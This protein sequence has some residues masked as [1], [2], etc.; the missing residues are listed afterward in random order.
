MAFNKQNGI[1]LIEI[2]FGIVISSLIILYGISSF[3]NQRQNEA[4]EQTV[5]EMKHLLQLAVMYHAQEDVWPSAIAVVKGQ[6]ILTEE[7][8][9]SPWPGDGMDPN[10]NVQ[11]TLCPHRAVYHVA[12]F[13]NQS[14][15]QTAKYFGISLHLSD[16]RLVNRIAALLPAAILTDPYTLTA[17]VSALV[18]PKQD[19]GWIMSGGIVDDG[20]VIDMPK[21][22]D[23]YEGHFIESPQNFT[24]DSRDYLW[25]EKIFNRGKYYVNFQ[26]S[27]EGKPG[28]N[29]PEGQPYIIARHHKYEN[30]KTFMSLAYF[31]TFCIPDGT[32]DYQVASSPQ[33]SQC[34]SE[35]Q[36]Y[37]KGVNGTKC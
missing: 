32:W 28:V 36:D 8:L 17:Y 35:W 9:C 37:N 10:S 33:A 5:S 4:V 1:G 11:N 3:R 6:H 19:K 30:T 27:M 25:L 18:R 21:C 29:D 13:A 20:G 15:A 22:Q 23:G 34:G 24:G 12:P 31:L 16:R 2:L 7:E 14:D 26:Y